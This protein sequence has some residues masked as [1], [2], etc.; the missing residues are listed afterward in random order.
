MTSLFEHLMDTLPFTGAMNA[1]REKHGRNL[2]NTMADDAKWYL[3]YLDVG[4]DYHAKL[5][6][7]PTKPAKEILDDRDKMNQWALKQGLWSW[8]HQAAEPSRI[9]DVWCRVRQSGYGS[10]KVLDS[11]EWGVQEDDGPFQN[12]VQVVTMSGLQ[13]SLPLDQK[14][15]IQKWV[16]Y[17]GW[18]PENATRLWRLEALIDRSI[19]IAFSYDVD[20]LGNIV[21][22]TS[23]PPSSQ[24]EKLEIEEALAAARQV[25]TRIDRAGDPIDDQPPELTGELPTVA[26]PMTWGIR[27]AGGNYMSKGGP[28]SAVS[29]E[30][31]ERRVAGTSGARILV[32]LSLSCCRERADYEPGGIVGMARFYPHVMVKANVPLETIEVTTRMTRPT[33]T[34][35]ADPWDGWPDAPRDCCLKYDRPGKTL[36]GGF[37]ADENQNL[38]TFPFS[39]APVFPFWSNMFSYY[40]PDVYQNAGNGWMAAV[41]SDRPTA[42]TGDVAITRDVVGKMFDVEDLRKEA[43]QGEFDNVHIAPKLSIARVTKAYFQAQAEKVPGG[44]SSPFLN[45]GTTVTI[46][47]AAAHMQD[48]TMAPFCAHD[49]FHLHWR[50]GKHAAASWA[51]GWDETGPFMVT[52]APLVP[53]N[54]DVWV[55]MVTPVSFDYRAVVS[56]PRSSYFIDPFEWQVIMHHGAA[57]VV[58]TKDYVTAQMAQFAVHVLGCAC[59][60]YDDEG[61]WVTVGESSALFYWLLRYD[62][63]M[64]S[65]GFLATERTVYCD[66]NLDKARDL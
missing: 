44:P 18:V 39:A 5:P 9:S 25:S 42:R 13:L 62:A 59:Q 60:F 61:H 52:G 34:T 20:D 8:K 51:Q 27:I 32:V 63:N 4:D 31:G 2:I 40:M 41:R 38:A 50:W 12:C 65:K 48:I 43:R 37:W 7:L 26:D 58:S 45:Q 46:D 6:P 66:G 24:M 22:T 55:S 28:S 17:A 47:L 29:G 33:A 3:G 1:L 64:D 56:P 35:S 10:Y 23:L 57:Y 49:C 54:Q 19:V 30:V 16:V 53:L 21:P 11:I 36:S 14:H 15:V